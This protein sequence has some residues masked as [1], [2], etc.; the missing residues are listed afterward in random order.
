M[1]TKAAVQRMEVNGWQ[2]EQVSREWREKQEEDLY[3]VNLEGTGGM[4]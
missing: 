4:E 1:A 3:C 2:G